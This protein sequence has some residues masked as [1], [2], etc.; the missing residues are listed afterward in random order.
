MDEAGLLSQ[1]A[2]SLVG[3]QLGRIEAFSSESC[4]YAFNSFIERRKIKFVL[5]VNN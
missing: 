4:H 2:S 1:S 5:H 3:R